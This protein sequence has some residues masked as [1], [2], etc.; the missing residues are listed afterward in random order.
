[1]KKTFLIASALFLQLSAFS[2]TAQATPEDKAVGKASTH[3]RH[4]DIAAGPSK[5]SMNEQVAQNPEKPATEAQVAVQSQVQPAATTT[6]AQP[7]LTRVESMQ[8]STTK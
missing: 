3:Y 2:L 8:A 7:E 4:L 5:N 1:M 6:G